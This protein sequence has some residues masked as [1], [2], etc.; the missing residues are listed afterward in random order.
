M[1]T[2]TPTTQTKSSTDLR[3]RIWAVANGPDL[4]AVT[5]FSTV[6]LLASI[7]FSIHFP[8]SDQVATLLSQ[9]P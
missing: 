4:I 9:A 1:V 7:Y 5:L 6:G 8:M 3:D 2:I